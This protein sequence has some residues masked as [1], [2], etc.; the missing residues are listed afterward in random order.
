MNVEAIEEWLTREVQSPGTPLRLAKNE[1]N[2]YSRTLVFCEAGNKP[3]A[4]IFV[5]VAESRNGIDNDTHFKAEVEGLSIAQTI[6]SNSRVSVPRLH[7][8]SAA[9]KA[10]AI[11]FIEGRPLFNTIWNHRRLH[12]L[13]GPLNAAHFQILQDLVEWMRAFHASGAPNVR[14]ATFE[15]VLERD[16]DS[17][18]VRREFL[19]QKRNVWVHMPLVQ[20]AVSS[21]QS[22]AQRLRSTHP[23]IVLIHGDLTLYNVISSGNKAHVIDFA[24]S[25]PGVAEDDFSRIVCDLINFEPMAA[26]CLPDIHRKDA[27]GE[28]FRTFYKS[29]PY[30]EDLLGLF[31]ARNI[32]INIS[33]YAN[34]MNSRSVI[35]KARMVFFLWIQQIFLRSILNKMERSFCPLA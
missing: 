21:A 18:V 34:L 31:L 17:M 35:E 28:V 20:K 8:Y 29:R 27:L 30:N 2:P 3:G 10:I 5:K 22:A 24:H 32:L 9:L 7:G 11:Q 25:R 1:N 14:A 6:R 12:C 4:K 26:L 16:L 15:A 13:I 33:T 19:S 23:E